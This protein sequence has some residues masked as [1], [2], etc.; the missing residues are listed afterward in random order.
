MFGNSGKGITVVII[1]SAI[2]YAAIF[3]LGDASKISLE[4]MRL[5]FLALAFALSFVNYVIRMVRF[6]YYLK[7]TSVSIRGAA[8]RLIFFSGLS[9]AVTP[10]KFGEVFKSYLIRRVNGTPI[11]RS[12]PVIITER[13][14]DFIGVLILATAA[15]FLVTRSA[16]A[17]LG[18]LVAIAV[19]IAAIKWERLFRSIVSGLGKVPILG[20]HTEGIRNVYSGIKILHGSVALSASTVLSM[21][22]WLAECVGFWLILT[23]LGAD[24]PLVTCVF[25]YTI[26]TIIGVISNLPGGIGAVEGGM[27]MMLLGAGISGDVAATSTIL[28]RLATL[29]FAVVIGAIFLWVFEKKLK[30]L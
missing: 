17:T 2:I 3:I 12:L 16:A 25:I 30:S 8:R 7:L 5:E 23:G 26:S 9:M 27:Y 19:F 4:G 11:S 20:R 14:N 24:I 22:G 6:E 29:W 18:G 10:G 28:I 13:I 21:G 15:S 1:V